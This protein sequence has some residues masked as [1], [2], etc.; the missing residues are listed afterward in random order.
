MK[1]FFIA[2]YDNKFFY[3]GFGRQP[4][5]YAGCRVDTCVTTGDRSRFPLK[6]IDAVLFHYR[7][8][9]TSFPAQR[10][11]HTRYIFW[12]L[13]SPAHLFRDIVPYTNVYNWTFTY[14]LN[15]DF[16]MPYG[17]VYRRK[18]PLGPDTKNYAAGKT[19]FAAWFVSNCNTI[20]GRKLLVNTLRQ[21]IQID[22]YGGCGDLRCP[23]DMGKSCYAM[24]SKNYKFYLSFENSLCQDYVTEKFFNILR[25][26]VIPV[27]Y[28]GANYSLQAP[29]HSYIN[30]LSFPT[31]KALAHYLIYL[32]NNDTAYNEYFRWK[33]FHRIPLDWA[34]FSKPY[35][36]LCERL[37]TDN[38]TKMYN[39]QKWFVEDSH[40]KT[41]HD[42]DISDFINGYIISPT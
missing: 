38:S 26:D 1:R 15:S 4:F 5:L 10:F 36:D 34:T 7:S 25:L 20:G 32:H 39:L 16:A 2:V 18:K 14:K 31:A 41:K 19:K 23:K 9:D 35:C 3:F 21:W 24:V 28:G 6:D 42:L 13:E 17:R 11:A 37:H 30:A 12:L 40:C 29:P 33:R 22:Q 27:V 8:F